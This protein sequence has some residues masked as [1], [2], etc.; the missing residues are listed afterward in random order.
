MIQPAFRPISAQ[1]AQLPERFF[2]RVHATPVSNPKV[3]AANVELA[4][5]FGV[6]VDLTSAETLSILAGNRVPDGATPIAMAYAGHQFGHFVP[7]LGDGRAILLGDLQDQSGRFWELHLKGAGR[8]PFSR[9]GDGRAALGPVI[10]EYILSEAMHALGI[11]TTRALAA[12][13]T[14][15]LVFRDTTQPGAILVRMA[16][17]H[18]RVGTFEYFACRHD[19]KAIQLL[20]DFAIRRL[21]PD[22]AQADHPYLEFLARVINQHAR[23]VAEWMSVGFIHGVMNTDNTAISGETI[24]YGP[25]AFVDHYDPNAVFSSIDRFGRYSY[26]QQPT[27]AA[28]NLARLAETL[29]PL[30]DPN[31]EVAVEK[32][33]AEIDQ[34]SEK[35]QVQWRLKMAAKLGIE[36][37]N[38]EDDHL[39]NRFLE[40][41]AESDGD[42]TLSF[43]AINTA[44]DGDPELLRQ[45]LKG[46]AA[47]ES[48]ICDWQSRVGRN[49]DSGS[50]IRPILAQANP[51]FIPRN[52]LIQRA[53]DQVVHDQQYSVMTDLMTVLSRPYD[54]QPE[55]EHYSRAPESHE[56]VTQTF[57]GT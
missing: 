30:I 34:F 16:R 14:G 46:T 11:P 47:S 38:P 24:D 56:R 42:F 35:F 41:L 18:I 54:P 45:I 28:W 6:S 19:S 48:W 25:C 9:M 50:K 53:I 26:A 51:I 44:F 22:L 49:R 10:R 40:L 5:E 33:T 36:A 3:L 8:T 31:P 12:L 23:L 37:P 43:R 15:D 2:E 29:L 20:A 32:A 52:H 4:H 21:Y 55:F 17:S 7:Q 27:I 39:I 13:T 1:Y 57:C